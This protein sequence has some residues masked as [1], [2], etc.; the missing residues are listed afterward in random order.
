M[1]MGSANAEPILRAYFP[2]RKA[3]QPEQKQGVRIYVRGRRS[4]RHR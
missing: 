4:A 1:G 3:K 2:C